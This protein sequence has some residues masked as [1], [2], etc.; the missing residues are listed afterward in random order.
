M[1]NSLANIMPKI[2]ARGLLTLRE[3]AV[4]PRLVN[5]DYSDEAK[6]KG[7]TIDVP[8]PTAAS[9]ISVTPS[10]VPPAGV[11]ITPAKVQI[12]LDQWK[13][14]DPFNLT[15]KEMVEVDK[16]EHYLPMQASEAIKALANTVNAYIHAQ[17]AGIYGYVG[18]AGTTPF[19]VSV[20]DATQA[21]KVLNQ[22]LCPRTDRRGVL[23]FDAEA[24]ALELS[25]FSDAEKVGS[26]VVKM[27]GEIGRK[28]GI[29]WVA[30]DAIGT[31]T[32]GTA[33]GAT[34]DNAGYAIGVTTFTLASAGTGT[35]LV[36][37]I[38][39]IAGDTQTYAVITGD[40]D[41]SGGGTVVF[42]PPLKVAI[43]TSA[44]AITLKATHVVNLAF[45][46][47]AFAF[48]TRP[49]VANTQDLALGSKILS[50]QDPQTGLVL[51]LEV[52]RQHKRVAWEFDILYGAKLVRPE[53]AVR[54]AG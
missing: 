28:F 17:Y 49:L 44:T 4:M 23:D 27:D 31:H 10:Q 41:V 5:S 22:Q 45:H 52:S 32:A 35:I 21:R 53:L 37:D 54:I 25:P 40:A 7:D 46:R 6:E 16:N 38:F 18:T 33:S 11:S 13:Q 30:D 48:A 39:T 26:A 1:A 12:A 34:T 20:A 43:T 36:G 8:I 47:D 29:N 51:R 14:N 24:Q 3:L 9:V 19:G 2:L 50:I 42:E 15:D